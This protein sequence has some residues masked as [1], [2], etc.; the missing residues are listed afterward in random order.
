MCQLDAFLYS[1]P[2]IKPFIT[3]EL[4]LPLLV[5][6]PLDVEELPVLDSLLLPDEFP[7][8][9]SVIVVPLELDEEVRL[10][11]LPDPVPVSWLP[12]EVVELVEPLELEFVELSPEVVTSE[13]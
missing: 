7:V 1:V 11:P 12:F 13:D 2:P 9:S 6:L 4:P 3:P 10:L 5:E 8:D